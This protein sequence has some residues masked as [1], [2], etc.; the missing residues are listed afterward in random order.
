MGKEASPPQGRGSRDSPQ[1]TGL[2]QRGPWVPGCWARATR[3]ERG[4]SFWAAVIPPPIIP[5]SQLSLDAP[6]VCSQL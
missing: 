1:G 3:I 4:A 5:K 2:V 6:L